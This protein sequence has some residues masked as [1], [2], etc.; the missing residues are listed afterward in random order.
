MNDAEE[1]FDI[2]LYLKVNEFRYPIVAAM[3]RDILS[4]HISTVVS[5]SSFSVG[6][7]VNDQYRSLLKPNIIEALVYTRDW[8][9]EEKYNIC[10]LYIYFFINLYFFY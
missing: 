10:Y 4:I 5:E 6:G 9:Y 1:N 7:H 8:L 3:A 2:L